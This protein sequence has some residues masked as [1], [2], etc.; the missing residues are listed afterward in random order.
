MQQDRTPIN[1]WVDFKVK[2]NVLVFL[3]KGVDEVGFFDEPSVMGDDVIAAYEKYSSSLQQ[4]SCLVVVEAATAPSPLIRL[5]YRIFKACRK[6]GG[7]LYV[8]DFPDEFQISL[9]TLALTE[10][11]GFRLRPDEES[12]LD[13]INAPK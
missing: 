11:P 6:K 2:R 7:T 1:R 5:I 8:C 13:E 3:V 4:S 10:Q 12:V 9:S